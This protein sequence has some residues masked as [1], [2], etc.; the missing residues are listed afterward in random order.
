[1]TRKITNDMVAHAR[2]VAEKKGRNADWVEK[3][4]RESVAVTE[5]EALENNIID[6]D[7]PGPG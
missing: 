2:S 7:R 4:V 6:I 5:T 3:A 1:M